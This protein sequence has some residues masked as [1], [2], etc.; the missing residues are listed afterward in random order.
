MLDINFYMQFDNVLDMIRNGNKD[1]ERIFEY[2][3]SIRSGHPVVYNIETTNKCNMRCKM[4]PR[5][6]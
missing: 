1:K 6:Q 2:L 5:P 4:C 3:D